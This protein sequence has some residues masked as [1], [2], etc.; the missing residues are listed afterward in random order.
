M[1]RIYEE[2][3][4]ARPAAP[5]YRVQPVAT[6]HLT[7][8]TL[9]LQRVLTRTEARGSNA[10]G[11]K[12]ASFRS[13]VLAC[14]PSR[15]LVPCRSFILPVP[16][17]FLLRLVHLH[18]LKALERR[19]ASEQKPRC[20]YHHD[21]R[22]RESAFYVG[23][24]YM[25][26]GSNKRGFEIWPVTSGCRAQ[27]SQLPCYRNSGHK[28]K[29]QLAV[30]ACECR[31]TAREKKSGFARLLSASTRPSIVRGTRDLAAS[32]CKPSC[33]HRG[34]VHPR[35]KVPPRRPFARLW[36][37]RQ[38]TDREKA[39][40]KEPAVRYN[41]LPLLRSPPRIRRGDFRGEI[42]ATA[43]PRLILSILS[44]GQPRSRELASFAYVRG[45]GTTFGRCQLSRQSLFPLASL[46]FPF[47]RSILPADDRSMIEDHGSRSRISLPFALR[48]VFEVARCGILIN[49]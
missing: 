29:I 22:S 49:R 32:G 38:L 9:A 8:P 25:R 37:I 41:G 19:R 24:S 20:F 31:H 47:D 27:W 5:T 7:V 11:A 30:A 4:R 2:S 36:V 23:S 12:P 10:H 40:V 42:R 44:L 17:S 39:V 16:S 18:S 28:V 15:S 34:Y 6:F 13:Y 45:R 48:S 21:V 33:T 14:P 26:K 3:D 35:E 1:R 46:L 43:S